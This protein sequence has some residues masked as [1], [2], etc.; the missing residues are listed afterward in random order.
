MSTRQDCYANYCI[1]FR[2][3]IINENQALEAFYY[4]L[5][6]IK[7]INLKKYIWLMYG[8]YNFKWAL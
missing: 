6:K 8:P 4:Y 1:L 5:Q 7:N 3:M 2:N